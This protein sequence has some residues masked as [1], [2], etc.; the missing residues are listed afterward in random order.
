VSPDVMTRPLT[1]TAPR[2]RELSAAEFQQFATLIHD[3]AGISLHE[4]KHSLMVR[5]L[6]AR[7]Q[8]LGLTSFGDYYDHVWAD[9]T[10]DELVMLLDL[11]TTN[12]THFFREPVHFDLLEHRIFP[13]WLSDAA[14]GRRERRL[15][16][17]SAACSTGQEPYSLAM[18]LLA[19]FPAT[20]GWHVE[21]LATDVSTRALRVAQQAT[22]SAE[23]AK[24]IPE[25]YLT[26][27]MLRGVGDNI[28]LMRAT[29][30]L[31]H[32]VKFARM[33]LNDETYPVSGHFDLIFCRNVLIYFSTERRAAV[34]E[35]LTERLTPTGMLFVGHAESLHAHRTRLTPVIPTVYRR[36]A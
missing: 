12:E 21:L 20:H 28:G 27:Y 8:E 13:Q 26:E 11:I 18:L 31:R 1:G 5:R 10:G 29:S 3:V 35:R 6:G 30:E 19:H 25:R 9:G 34:I 2:L 22:W 7:V 17:W 32:V 16:V 33:N 23:K 36:A 14:A 4:S 24:E 15:R